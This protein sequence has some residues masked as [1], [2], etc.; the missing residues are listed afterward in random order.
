MY[1]PRNLNENN[2]NI[3]IE[4]LEEH[5]Q[6]DTFISTIYYMLTNKDSIEKG[7]YIQTNKPR[8]RI[9]QDKKIIPSSHYNY[10][11]YQFDFEGEDDDSHSSI[12]RRQN[13]EIMRLEQ[14]EEDKKIRI[15]LD[16]EKRKQKEKDER[17][18]LH[19]KIE[20]QKTF[21]NMKLFKL[22]QLP[23]EPTA[24]DK[25][26]T[27][28]LFRCPDNIHRIE[29]RFSKH[30]TVGDMYNFIETLDDLSFNKE[31]KFELIQ[32]FPFILFNDTSKTLEEEKLFPNA[33]IQ[34][35]EI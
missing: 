31:G 9:P 35:R 21:K 6:E 4:K 23:I 17:D 13:Q 20:E 12:I 10:E 18:M 16:D 24:D 5:F 28:I 7:T 30:D 11:E 29:R 26:S 33:V 8:T 1:N 2:L 25:N 15:K 3:I 22:K 14:E 19:K 27:H 32:P 34:I